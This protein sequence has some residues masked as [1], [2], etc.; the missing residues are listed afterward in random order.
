MSDGLSGSAQDAANQLIAAASKVANEAVDLGEEAV[1]VVLGA[2]IEA[3]NLVGAALQ[4]LKNKLV[5]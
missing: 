2:V 4:T 5:G 3:N 1:A